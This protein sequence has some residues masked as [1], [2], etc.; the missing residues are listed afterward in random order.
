[1]FRNFLL[2]RLSSTFQRSLL[3]SLVST[4]YLKY[5][6]IMSI[7]YLILSHLFCRIMN[8]F[9]L[10]ESI[11][12][13]GF[14]LLTIPLP[15]PKEEAHASN[16]QWIIRVK[17][18]P[19]NDWKIILKYQLN[20][21][22][23]IYIIHIFLLI[24]LFKAFF[25]ALQIIIRKRTKSRIDIEVCDRSK[26]WKNL[27]ISS[28]FVLLVRLIDLTRKQVHFN[29]KI[30][31][32]RKCKMILGKCKMILGNIIKRKNLSDLCLSGGSLKVMSHFKIV[33]KNLP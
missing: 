18:R 28:E 5:F 19:W 25:R 10:G 27:M 1:M 7:I 21:G 30:I 11:F 22:T 8:F 14:F 4:L 15:Q 6:I 26:R 24:L 12:V 31:K 32:E 20:L 2:A 33:T 3:C 13:F 17:E 29:W 9:L 16:R 23:S